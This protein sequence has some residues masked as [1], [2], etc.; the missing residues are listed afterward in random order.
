[1][2]KDR[3]LA[4]AY[5]PRAMCALIEAD[6]QQLH[7]Y[8]ELAIQSPQAMPVRRLMMIAYAAEVGDAALLRTHLDKLQ[9]ISPDFI[10]SLFRGEYPFF[11]K[12]EHM[13]L[14]L[15]TNQKAGLGR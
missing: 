9:S 2:P 5:A 1:S 10:P 13:K 7:D 12:P 4:G 11:R 3:W 6:W 14:L 8:A 15:D